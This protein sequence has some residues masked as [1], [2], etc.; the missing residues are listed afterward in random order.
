MAIS[1][2]FGLTVVYVKDMERAKRFYVEV[3]GLKVERE[4]PSFVQFEHFALATDEPLA[5]RG[6]A[7]LYW[8]VDDAAAAHRDMS[9]KAPISRPLETKPFGKV[10]GVRDPD[11]GARLLLE[12]ARD[13]PSKPV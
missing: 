12:L 13:R 6:E 10:F 7:E 1:S 9:A 2:R 5:E 4:A 3:L 8:L 11:G